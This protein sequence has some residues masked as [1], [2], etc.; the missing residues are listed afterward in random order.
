MKICT[1][2]RRRVLSWPGSC[3]LPRRCLPSW[4]GW[5]LH[6]NDGGSLGWY[7]S[8]SGLADAL[9]KVSPGARQGSLPWR[10]LHPWQGSCWGPC[11]HPRQGSCR[12]ACGLPRLGSRRGSPSSGPD[13]ILSVSLSSQRSACHHGGASRAL[14]PTWLMVLETV[15]SRVAHSAGVGEPPRQGSCRGC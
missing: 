4:L 10:C 13:L 7:G 14:V 15:G 2:P 8:G 6:A 11:C 9:G 12:G 1:P 5:Q 3:M